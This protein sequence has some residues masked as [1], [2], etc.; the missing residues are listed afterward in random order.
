MSCEIEK[1]LQNSGFG[2]IPR[3]TILL[4]YAP[5]FLWC[6]RH[7]RS[8]FHLNT[9]MPI[10]I[11]G[12]AL[13][14]GPQIIPGWDYIV[15]YGP[16]V[17]TIAAVKYYFGG[18]HNT[19]ERD[20]HGKVF[21]VTGG[22]S[23]VGAQV[24]YHIATKGAQVILLVRSTE[25]TWTVDFIED[26]RE[27]TNNSLIYAEQCDLNSLHSVRLFATK[28][29]DN[30]PARRLDGVICCASDT[31]PRGK[32]RQVTVD[33]VEK[34]MGINYLA[35]YHLLTLLQPSLQVQP[36][37]RD[38]RVLIATCASQALGAVDEEDLLWSNKKYPIGSP[39][40]LYGSSKL[41]LG[42]FSQHYQKVLNKYERP[43]K[44]DCNIRINTVNPGL[45]R[46]PSTRR[47]LSMG[48]IWGLMLYLILMP[49]W[50]IFF[51]SANQGS[52]SFVFALSNPIF[53]KIDGG[54]Q[55]QECKIIKRKRKEFDDEELQERV[56]LETAK[57]I[58]SLE[59]SSAIERKRQEKVNDEKLTL[60]EKLKKQQK[61][62]K[63]QED[64]GK[65]PQSEVELQA[66][67]DRLKQLISL[68]KPLEDELPLFPEDPR[69]NAAKKGKKG[70]GKKK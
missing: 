31:I 57:L 20:L 21:I 19:W 40:K 61:L 23:G 36:P 44:G 47:F 24:A 46:T 28:W 33:G 50:W 66:K 53:T 69:P 34:Q 37:D 67:L 9:T 62:R 68:G 3:P 60:K 32:P 43:D 59:K 1:C 16:I 26:L 39:W 41:L 30:K 48:K 10:D 65:V 15:K 45:M 6:L 56:F 4:L 38:V 63:E 29:L 51:K 25:D 12:S 7:H 42:L 5:I 55:I 2:S 18:T 11:L 54:N 14:E 52:Q 8:F 64:L 70:K 58:E 35:H 17:L 49:I 13:V 22:T 27:Q